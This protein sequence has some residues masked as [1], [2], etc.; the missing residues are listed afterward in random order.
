MGTPTRGKTTLWIYKASDGSIVTLGE[1]DRPDGADGGVVRIAVSRE[2]ARSWARDL[3]AGRIP[4][5]D[6]P[7]PGRR[8]FAPA[9]Q[10]SPRRA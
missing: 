10:P 5:T 8:A 1:H 2:L 6:E 4:S 9:P 3:R 7:D